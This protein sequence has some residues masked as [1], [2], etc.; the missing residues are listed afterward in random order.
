MGTAHLKLAVREVTYGSQA[1]DENEANQSA[2]R[3]MGKPD[4]G[5][6]MR[7]SAQISADSLSGY[8]DGPGEGAGLVE[9]H[10]LPLSYQLETWRW[11]IHDHWKQ[12][13]VVVGAYVLTFFIWTKLV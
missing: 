5:Y 4:I 12:A 1:N 7:S 8:F 13:V 9:S 3:E 2:E 6:P 11:Y 10:K